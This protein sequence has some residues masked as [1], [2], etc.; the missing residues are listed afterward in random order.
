MQMTYWYLY[1]VLTDAIEA[2]KLSGFESAWN[3]QILRCAVIVLWWDR[4]GWGELCGLVVGVQ[5]W[6]V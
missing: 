6:L 2:F 3:M 5:P 1:S 4:A